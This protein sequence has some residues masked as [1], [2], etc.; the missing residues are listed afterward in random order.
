METI[1]TFKIILE[2]E[3]SGV[4]FPGDILDGKLELKVKERLKINGIKVLING[5]SNIY[6]YFNLNP[7]Y[8]I[9]L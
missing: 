4:F 1:E 9:K 6:W 3:D 2:K 8:N 7:K 5:N